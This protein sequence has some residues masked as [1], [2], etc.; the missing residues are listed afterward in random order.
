MGHTPSS[1]QQ[2]LSGLENDLKKVGRLV[3]FL[4]STQQGTLGLS[5]STQK[6]LIIFQK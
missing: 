4:S 1:I 5:I 2:L 6:D 3:S